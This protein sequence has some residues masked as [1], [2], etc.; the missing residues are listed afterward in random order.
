MWENSSP[1]IA[2]NAQTLSIS[3]ISNYKFILI[4]SYYISDIEQ[5]RVITSNYFINKIGVTY[6]A[7]SHPISGNSIYPRSVTFTTN[8]ITFGNGYNN[9][10][11]SNTCCVPV[12]IYGIK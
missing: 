3:D 4:G 10:N 12:F 2:F 8:G 11:I 5:H 9:S 7:L 6:T 1:T